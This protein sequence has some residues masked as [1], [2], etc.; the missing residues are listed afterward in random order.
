MGN[1]APIV[2]GSNSG[3]R[4]RH[5]G[6]GVTP[7]EE[8]EGGKGEGESEKEECRQVRNSVKCSME[9]QE[10]PRSEYKT[11]NRGNNKD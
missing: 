11:K 6:G 8:V 9:K 10:K 3:R 7:A 2:F 1:S 4:H 5:C